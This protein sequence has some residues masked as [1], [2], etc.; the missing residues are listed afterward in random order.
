MSHVSRS[1][2]IL[3]PREKV[4][5]FWQN[6]ENLP[7]F[8]QHLKEVR[9]TGNGRS[10]WVAAAP[11]GMKV[12]WDAEIVEEV[13]LERITWRSLPDSQIPNHGSVRFTDAPGDRGT[14]V[15]VQLDYEAP[16]GKV[17]SAIAKLLGEDPDQQLRDDLRRFK[18]VVE[19]GE[20]VRSEGSLEGA[21]QGTIKQRAAQ[22]LEGEAP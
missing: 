11:A 13:P 15:H 19:T 8:M 10:H 16:A 14:E 17:G 21:G 22:P 18:Q 7:R 2:T 3:R 1:V 20:V 9:R 4:Y 12:E 6:L 5:R